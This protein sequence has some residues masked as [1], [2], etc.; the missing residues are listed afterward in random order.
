MSNI[1][2]LKCNMCGMCCKAI[3][4]RFSPEEI[5]ARVKEGIDDDFLFADKYWRSI[6]KEE[7]LVINPHIEKL[8]SSGPNHFYVCTL[9]IDGVGCSVHNGDG[10]VVKPKVCTS[11]P[12][13]NNLDPRFWF[14]SETCGY[15]PPKDWMDSMLKGINEIGDKDPD[16]EKLKKKDDESDKV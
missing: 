4:I 3:V 6:S 14:Y 9:Y 13:G 8:D 1:E 15:K 2:D 11:Y 7:A 5:L 10:S 16:D 12:N